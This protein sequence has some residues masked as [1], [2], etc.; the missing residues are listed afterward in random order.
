MPV[1]PKSPGFS[2]DTSK[3]VLLVDK[4]R[5]DFPQSLFQAQKKTPQ[6]AIYSDKI[7]SCFSLSTIFIVFAA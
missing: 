2:T 1:C 5:K 7:L 4:S 6:K 3:I